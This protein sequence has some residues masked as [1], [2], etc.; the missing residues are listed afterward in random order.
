M[1]KVPLVR[2]A[3]WFWPGKPPLAH[4]RW[5]VATCRSADLARGLL[6]DLAARSSRPQ[7]L[8][9]LD[10]GRYEGPWPWALLPGASPERVLR[11]LQPDS[12]LFLDDSPRTRA[13][14]SAAHC[15]V[16]WI[17]GQSADL[18]A[19]GRVTVASAVW[20]TAMGGGLV[21]GDPCVEWPAVPPAVADMAFC[22]RF[23]GVRA[24][25]RWLIYFAGTSLGE[26][27]LAY[28]TFL[29]MS[30]RSGGL[31]ALAPA[32]EARYEEVYR[33]SIKYHLLTTRQQRLMTSELPP[34][35]RVYYIE[36][37]T[38]RRAMYSCA[39][40]IV[41]GGTFAPGPA[42]IHEALHAGT[43]VV[44]GPRRDDPW[45]V[46]AVNA[47]VVMACADSEALTVAGVKLV[48]DPD[49]RAR[50]AQVLRDWVILQP[51]ARTRL[52][53]LLEGDFS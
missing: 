29:A 13:L 25:G 53:S 41:V 47:G 45:V 21:I 3:Q 31:L 33:E 43:S 44:V 50:Y 37:Q 34:K 30:A 14:A 10:E 38:A 26:E 40:V 52:M 4:A 18:L 51:G 6:A 48:S 24:A 2:L 23:R 12:L 46:A 15:P 22:A 20:A 5:V 17:N 7:A 27:A 19:L 1:P 49:A 8:L 32:D 28:R 39:D 35:T 36:E 42:A 9:L 16:W 11:R